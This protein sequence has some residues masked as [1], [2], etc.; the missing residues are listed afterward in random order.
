MIYTFGDSHAVSGWEQI[1]GVQPAWLGPLTLYTFGN[2][3]YD[4]GLLEETVLKAGDTVIY[5]LGEIDCRCQIYKYGGDHAYDLTI[6]RL[7][8]RY[9]KTVNRMIEQYYAVLGITTCIYTVPPPSHDTKEDMQYPFM[10]SDE[11]RKKYHEYINREIKGMCQ[12]N[13]FTYFD[14]YKEYSDKEGF[15]SP[16]YSKCMH[17]VNPKF[18]MEKIAELGLRG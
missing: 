18:I 4:V 16:D 6:Q 9:A 12:Q 5:C 11:T 10:G 8:K 13:G 17:I 1:A 3:A 7:V 14:V 2:D 15:L